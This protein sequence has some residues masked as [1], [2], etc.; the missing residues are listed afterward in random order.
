MTI[1][2]MGA[3]LFHAARQTDSQMVRQTRLI[4]T[5]HNFANVPKEWFTTLVKWKEQN[6]FNSLKKYIQYTKTPS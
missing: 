6:K 1:C 3:K 2:P 5:F 4:I